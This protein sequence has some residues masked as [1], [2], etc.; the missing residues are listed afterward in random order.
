MGKAQSAT[1]PDTQA[2]G[3]EF[4]RLPGARKPLCLSHL[5][6]DVSHYPDDEKEHGGY[7]KTEVDGNGYAT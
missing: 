3:R 6:R 7:S 5:P 2:C 4:F 1:R